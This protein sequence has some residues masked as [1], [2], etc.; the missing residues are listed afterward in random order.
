MNFKALVAEFVGTFTL[1]FIGVGAIAADYTTGG[2]VGLTG[3]ALAHGLAIAVMISAVVAISGGHLNPAVTIGLLSAGKIDLKSALGYVISQCLAAIVAIAVI[4]LCVPADVLW[5]IQ[6][7]V[8]A[9]SDSP[10]VTAMTALVTEIVLSFFLIFV[11]YGT[12]V[13]RR[14]PKMGGLFI[15]LAVAMGIMMGG[16]ISG[17]AMNPARHLG[18]ALLGGGMQNTWLYWAGPIIGAILAA[19][20]YKY[21][22]EEKAV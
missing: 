18:P 11:V 20:V 9:V 22:L 13:D 8:P 14:A 15:G 10:D 19:Q 16:P 1:V 2:A 3:V 5:D 7:G 4:K 21:V 17:A 6:Y 12:V